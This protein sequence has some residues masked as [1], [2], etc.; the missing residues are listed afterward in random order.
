MHTLSYQWNFLYE[1]WAQSRLLVTPAITVF[2]K[3]P[4]SKR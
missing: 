3:T 1:V 2:A 4:S